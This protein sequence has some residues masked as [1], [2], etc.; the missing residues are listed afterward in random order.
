[1]LLFFLAF[2]IDIDLLYNILFFFLGVHAQ[3]S[4]TESTL[5]DNFQDLV[6][7]H[8]LNLILVYNLVSNGVY[9]IE[10][11]NSMIEALFMC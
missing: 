5:T 1:M 8:F 2:V 4:I 11:R 3:V 6:F 10:V 7:R 9:N